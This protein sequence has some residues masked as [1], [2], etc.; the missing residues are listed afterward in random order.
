MPA[1][2]LGDGFTPVHLGNEKNADLAQQIAINS[3]WVLV[4][5][6]LVMFMQAGFAFLEIGFS[7]GKNVGTVVAK[8]LVNFSIAA[9]CFWAVD[10]AIAF[11]EGNAIIGTSG[12]FL[13]G[14]NAGL[15]FPLLYVNEGIAFITPETLWFFQFVFCGVSLAIVWGTTLERIKF[16]VYIIYAVIFA[17]ILYPIGAHWI[18]GGGWL[19]VEVGMQDF[20]GSTVVHLIGASGALAVLLLLGARKGKYGPTAS[21]GR[22]PGTTCRSSAWAS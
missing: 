17:S 5:G 13:D 11:G 7:R 10:F 1:V 16:G 15:S 18:F 22:S 4:A 21:H 6:I 2:A 19:Q 12:F 8:I 14:V 20:A 9:I 3:I